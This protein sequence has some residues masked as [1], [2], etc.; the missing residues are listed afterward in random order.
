MLDHNAGFFVIIIRDFLSPEPVEVI[1]IPMKLFSPYTPIRF[2]FGAS[3]KNNSAASY[4]L[5]I[6]LLLE[7]PLDYNSADKM[8]A[9]A[10]NNA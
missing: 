8:V 2:E 3:H 7:T 4:K 10:V 6:Q 9:I 1:C 5:Y